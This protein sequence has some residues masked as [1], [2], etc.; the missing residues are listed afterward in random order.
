MANRRTTIVVTVAALGIAASV[1]FV[2]GRIARATDEARSPAEMLAPHAAP[3]P[4]LQLIGTFIAPDQETLAFRAG[5]VIQDIKVQ[6]GQQVKAG[7]VLAV[8]DTTTLQ[9]GVAQA[10]TAVSLAQDRLVQIKNGAT[11]SDVTAARAALSA[12]Q[13]NYAKV[14]A[15]PTADDIAPLKAQLDTAKAALDQAQSIYDRAGGATNPFIQQLPQSL[16]LQ[17][18]TNNYNAALGTYQNALSHPTK[19][20]LAAAASQVQQAQ[21]GLERLQPTA[22]NIQIALD[23]V[24]QAQAALALVQQQLSDARLIAPRDGTVIWLGPHVGEVANPGAPF[25]ILADL[26]H[27]Q[28]QVGVEEGSLSTVKIGQTVSIVP[29]AFKDKTLEGNVVRVGWLATTT[30]G[31]IDV[32]V[33][34]D[35]NPSGVPLRPGLSAMAEIQTSQQ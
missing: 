29:E 16:A 10:N 27:L 9:L 3:A 32:P 8:L 33:I 15:G 6:E 11:E 22:D 21:A 13:Q 5:G 19:A 30:S 1:F 18:A 28:L 12:A 26:T 14:A 34:I 24:D 35:V 25:L 20:E 7:D 2:S 31:V 4:G 23:Q 17:Q